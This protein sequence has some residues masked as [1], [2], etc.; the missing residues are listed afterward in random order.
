MGEHR[1]SMYLLACGVG[2]AICCV[3]L[4]STAGETMQITSTAKQD[5]NIEFADLDAPSRLVSKHQEQLIET[6]ISEAN[7]A[8]APKYHVLVSGTPDNYSFY[9][10]DKQGNLVTLDKENIFEQLR[11][12]EQK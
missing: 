10:R 6:E 7:V 1:G 12:M 2:I 8:L 5:Y 11:A 4:I 3:M 9:K